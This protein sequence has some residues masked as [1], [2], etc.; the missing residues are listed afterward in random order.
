MT[1]G[2]HAA[3]SFD[4]SGTGGAEVFRDDLARW[5]RC[6]EDLFSRNVP[7]PLEHRASWLSE[8]S[9]MDHWFVVSRGGDEDAVVA[10][11]PVER[12]ATRSLPGHYRL[13]VHR[14]GYASEPDGLVAILE[15]LAALAR[16]DPR[17][18]DVTVEIFSPDP[19]HRG[20]IERIARA[21][22]YEPAAG[23]RRYRRTARLPL[24]ASEDELLASFSSSCRRFIRDPE[25]KGYRVEKVEDDRWKA[26]MVELWNETFSRTGTAPPARA[27]DR[28]LAFA[29][30]H[31][32]LY[33]IVGTFGPTYPAPDSL[34]SFSSAMNNGDHGV[35]SD[36]ASTRKLDTTVALSYAPMW[37]LIRWAKSLGCEW[38]DMGGISEGTYQD[39]DD[40]RGGISD[41]KRRFTGDVVEVGGAW[42][43][44]PESLRRRL[45][46]HV[47]RVVSVLENVVDKSTAW[48]S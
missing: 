30:E 5:R 40:P 44:R 18:L 6:Q 38:F 29:R 23:Q 45:S 46:E 36:G 34:V 10:G 19:E 2:P 37:E 9:E 31:P 43:F 42:I 4:P 47:R 26:R 39:D 41:F 8:V 17:V 13:R 24:A 27:W 1:R 15:A 11:F 48:R 3:A 21:R 12:H 28:R 25:K 33:R 22:S 16:Q 14:F 20:R 35:F 7:V 32:E